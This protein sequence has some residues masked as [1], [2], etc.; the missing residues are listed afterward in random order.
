M[1]LRLVQ[2]GE[3][4]KGVDPS[5]HAIFGVRIVTTHTSGQVYTSYIAL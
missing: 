1:L 4:R 3:E 2:T 5:A